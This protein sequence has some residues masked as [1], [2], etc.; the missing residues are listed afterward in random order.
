M[1]RATRPDDDTPQFTV[2]PLF[3]GSDDVV[4]QTIRKAWPNAG[5]N[6]WRM[7]SMD[8]GP[9]GPFLPNSYYC[10]AVSPQHRHADGTPYRCDQVRGHSSSHLDY[11]QPVA[12]RW[13]MPVPVLAPA[14]VQ[15][16][17]MGAY[18]GL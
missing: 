7:A 1:Y 17:V 6:A 16:A 3:Y 14:W 2:P 13:T 11:S 9:V 5:V 4:R 12:A 15:A 10:Q 18:M 8:V